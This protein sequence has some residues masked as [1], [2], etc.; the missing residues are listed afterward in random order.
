MRK[1]RKWKWMFLPFFGLTLSLNAE[2]KPTELPTLA[3]EA[4]SPMR[5]SSS[6]SSQTLDWARDFYPAHVFNVNEA[7]RKAPGIYVR[8]EEGFGIRPNIAFR[9]LN[10][11]RSTK[12]LFH[13]DGLLWNFAPYGDNDIYYHPPIERYV[14]VEII[15]GPDLNRFGPQTIGGAVNYLTPEVPVGLTGNIDFIGGT[16]DYKAGHVRLGG[17]NETAGLLLDYVHK[18]GLGSRR[19]TVV[20]LDDVFWKTR[21]TLNP[22]HQIQLYADYYRED[23]QSTFGLTEAEWRNFGPRYNPFPNDEFFTHR[24]ATTAIHEWRLSDRINLTTS[25]YWSRFH[26]DFWRQM[27][28]QPSDDYTRFAVAARDPDCV[29]LRNLRLRGQRLDVNECDFTRGRLRKYETWGLTPV[30]RASYQFLGI[31]GEMETGFRAHFED[32]ERR[33]E[34]GAAPKTRNGEPVEINKRYADAYAGYFQ[35]KFVLGNFSLTP[36]VRVEAIDYRRIN[37]LSTPNVRGDFTLTEPLPSLAM[38]YTP[39]PKLELFFGFHRGFAPPRVEDAVYNTSGGP[40]EID[41]ELSWNYEFGMH[42]RPFSGVKFDLTYFRMDFDTLTSV[43][44]I[45]GNDT[46]VAQGKALFQGMELGARLDAA[47][48]FNWSHNV[49]LQLAYTWIP[50]ADA[51]GTFRCLPQADGTISPACP[52][53]LVFGSRPGNRLPYAPE[54]LVTATVGYT[55]PIGLDLRFETVVVSEQFGDFMNLKSGFDHPNGP[56]SVEALSGQYG[57][58]PTYTVVNFAATYPIWQ[59]LDLFITVKNLLDN[60]YLVDRVRGMLPGPPRLVQA[61]FNYRFHL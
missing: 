50:T 53:G 46:P 10:P 29:N 24:W 51:E 47:E 56:E 18:E 59:D 54:H 60:R 27:N 58:I 37:R 43:G 21:L 19:E 45:G 26:R 35:N 32:Q 13:E 7:L 4:K 20:A 9:G 40:V 8:D 57:R 3:V 25:F 22:A 30:L 6:G 44:T 23:S 28:Q 49:Y 16:R 39:W 61:G 1:N 42:A 36:G 52:G 12:T 5:G 14:G 55:H 11:F 31:G 2:E 17:G 38:T 34:D 41:A 48:I 15:K 33:T